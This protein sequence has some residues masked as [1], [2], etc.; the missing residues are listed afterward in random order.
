M[1]GDWGHLLTWTL[2]L[3]VIS[4]WMSH[5]PLTSYQVSLRSDEKI[6]VDFSAT[7][8][9]KWLGNYEEIQ[10]SGLRDFRYFGL[11]SETVGIFLI[12][13]IRREIEFENSHFWNFKSHV[14]L[15]LTSTT[16]TNTTIWFNCGCIVFDCGR[17]TYV[18]TYVRT[19]GHFYR[20]Y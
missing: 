14:T 17:R 19:D 12:G 7:F 13:W 8:E 4:S 10:K 18:R 2:T 3:K 11:V 15:T 1:R 6:F 16:L 5:R 9:V 20:V